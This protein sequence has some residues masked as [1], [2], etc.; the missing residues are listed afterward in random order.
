LREH[1]NLFPTHSLF[2]ILFFLPPN[3]FL[4][5]SYW[6]RRVSV[7]FQFSFSSVMHKKRWLQSFSPWIIFHSQKNARREIR[8]CWK[9]YTQKF[10]GEE[11][12]LFN[13]FIMIFINHQFFFSEC[14]QE[15][16]EKEKILNLFI[17]T[18]KRGFFILLVNSI[19]WGCEDFKAINLKAIL[20]FNMLEYSSSRNTDNFMTFLRRC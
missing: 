2:F 16:S 6:R 14:L 19:G 13:G 4:K 15:K 9:R 12:F 18:C 17:E 11:F 3:L 8:R 5:R 20:I 10:Y 1:Q 7:V